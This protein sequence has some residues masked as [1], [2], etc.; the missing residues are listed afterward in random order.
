MSHQQIGILGKEDFVEP[1]LGSK[2]LPKILSV[3]KYESRGPPDPRDID[4]QSKSKRYL[5]FKDVFYMFHFKSPQNNLANAG[6]YYVGPEDRVRCFSCGGQF[7]MWEQWDFP[8]TRHQQTFPECPYLQE[9]KAKGEWK[10]C[11]YE[12]GL[13]SNVLMGK[14]LGDLSDERRRLETFRGHSGLFPYNRQLIMMAQAGFFYVGPGD[15]VK[16]FICGGELGQWE[17]WDV[18]LTRHQHSFPGCLY[19]QK[20]AAEGAGIQN[21]KQG[22]T[23]FSRVKFLAIHSPNIVGKKSLDDMTNLYSRADTYRGHH[24][25][26]LPYMK[27]WDMAQAGFYYVGPGDLVKCFICGGELDQWESWDEPLTRHQ[28]SFPDCAYVQEQRAQTTGTQDQSQVCPMPIKEGESGIPAHYSGSHNPGEKPLGDM[29]DEYSRLETYRGHSQ[30]FPMAN[31][32]KL[33][34]AGF[35]YVGPGDRVR[36]ISCGGELEKW[37]RW[38]VPLTRHQ[39]SF[40]HCPYMQ[41]LRDK[42]NGK[43]NQ[44]KV[45]AGPIKEGESGTTVPL[46]SS[47]NLEEKPCGYMSDEYSRL[48]S[49]RGH[50]QHFRILGK[51]EF[52]E[53]VLRTKLFP[54]ILSVNKYE[55]RG[56]PDPRD[57]DMQ[58]KSKRYLSFKDVFYMFHFKSPQNKLANAGFYYVGPRDRVRC[59]SC[60]G[61]LEMWEPWD[62]PL[63]RHQQTF[64][65]CPYLQELKAKGEWKDYHYE[66]GLGSNVLMGKPLGDLS[67]ERRR[68]E[69]FRG[70]SGLFPYYGQLIMMV[71]A[72]FFYV[73]PRDLV[74]C[75]ICGGELG[76]WESWD[77][78]LTR[79]QHSFPGC[80][81]VQKLAAEGAGI[82][83]QKQGHTGFSRVK[84]LIIGSPNILGKKSHDDMTNMY[85]RAETYR[86]HHKHF[87][88]YM[89][90]WDLA[91]AGFYYVGPRDLVKC[92][93]CGG[94]LDQWESWDEP[95]TRHQH[96]FPGCLY[97]QKLAAEGAGIQNQK[98]GHT[99]FSRVKSLTIE[100]PN[101]YSRADTY[102]RQH[103]PYMKEWDLAQAGFYYVGP[104]D[105]VKCFICGGELDKWERWDEPLTRHQNSFP[106]CAYVQEQRAQTT[107]TQDQSQVCPMPIKEGESGIPA[108]YSGSHN[109]GEKPLGDMNDEYSRLETYR[110]HSQYFPMANQRKLAQA[111]F[112]YVGPGDRVRCISCGGELEKW[113]R[114]DVP[115]TRHQHSFPHCPYIQKLRDE[116]DGKENQ[117]KVCAGIIKKGE[118]GTTVPLSSSSNLEEKPCGYMSD[119]YSRLESYRGHG[120]H[121][122]Y[123]NQQGLAKAGFYYVG[124]K[125]R[126]RCYS[127]GGELENWE[128]WYA[129]PIQDQR[130][131][132]DCL[133]LRELFLSTTFMVGKQVI[134]GM[135]DPSIPLLRPLGEVSEISIRIESYNVAKKHFPY[136]TSDKLAWAGFFYVGPGDRVRCFSCGGEVDNWEPGDVPL[137][138]HQLFF[139]HCSYVQGLSIRHSYFM[140]EGVGPGFLDTNILGKEALRDMSDEYSRI[141]S[142]QAVKEHFPNQTPIKLAWA[143]FYYVGPKEKVRCFSCGGEMDEWWSREDPL[144]EHHRRFPQCHFILG[145]KAV[146]NDPY[147]MTEMLKGL[148]NQQSQPTG[149]AAPSQDG[150]VSPEGNP[151]GG[152]EEGPAGGMAEGDAGGKEEGPVGVMEEGPV[153]AMEEGPVGAMEEGTVGAMVEGTVGGMEEGAAG[154]MEEGEAE[155]MEE[156]AAGEMEEGAA[157]EMEEGAAGGMELELREQE[158]EPYSWPKASTMECELCGKIPAATP[159]FPII[160]KRK[161]RLDLPHGGLFHCC[162]TGIMFHVPSP[163]VIEFTL[164][165]WRDSALQRRYDAV[166]PVFDVKVI[167]G[168]VSAVYLPHYVCLKAGNIDV[169]QFKIAHY[170]DD[171][172]VLESPTRVEPFYIVLENPTFSPV[173]VV[174]LR[175]MTEIFKVKTRIHGVVHLY[176]SYRTG[177]TIHLHFMPDDCSLH[178]AVKDK[179]KEHGFHFISKPYGTS[180]VFTATDYT[181]TAPDY[182]TIRPDTIP[183]RF[184]GDF[185]EIYIPSSKMEEEIEISLKPGSE[186]ETNSVWGATVRRE[187]LGSRSQEASGIKHFIDSNRSALIDRMSVPTINVVLDELLNEEILNDEQYSTVRSKNISQEMMRELYSYANSWSHQDK[188]M[189]FFLLSKHNNSL[190]KDLMK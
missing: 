30:Y 75:F 112:S 5:S 74:K 18:P 99:G 86:G 135:L 45:C 132:S 100:S 88:P 83:N 13:G 33:A 182:A 6:F 127:C 47:S 78:P 20:L 27:V 179:E 111:G 19:V 184:N 51:E 164:S 7:E 63:T 21:Q 186:T 174:L 44:S 42:G 81:Y 155:G 142:Y 176:C 34:Q 173:G 129:P 106:D 87:L 4:M 117:S 110:G 60:G 131:P 98:Q 67:D 68:L 22:H 58:S 36:C 92:F 48:Q 158:E 25:H 188:D 105:L 15:L 101:M 170:I 133:H 62:F 49:Y 91:Q 180:A 153:G 144:T 46:S 189:F 181:V 122:I 2:L 97:V 183:V 54:I 166:G 140:E 171:N 119:E 26:F 23:G 143:G 95:L 96:S 57:I 29:N 168:L 37:E 177:Y 65:E 137:T 71:L 190:V 128:F 79:H 150:P 14:P 61:Q 121:F 28:H 187:D 156:G 31:Q 109:P 147:T 126:V 104:G 107:G 93:I 39:H 148:T 50:G 185:S 43:E 161:Y 73:G 136:Q 72:G 16:C 162:E 151:P 10:D 125:D 152:L 9:L 55:S 114:W 77:V 82:Q 94:E 178:E 59:F 163:S 41:K 134:L 53:P 89:K 160:D 175:A 64:P 130:S 102:R 3:N 108:H 8:L 169:S 76:Q 70:H 149:T 120:Q 40:P 139:P 35:Y 11:H 1:V 124:P 113:E 90:E 141:Q 146:S 123:W 154:E 56:P 145:R 85:S 103:F 66:P 32:R 116:G 172:V 115:L 138:R 80:L 17:S 52:V 118:S 84:F 157:G 38:D 24:K 165:S 69:T 167:S 159:A 12:P